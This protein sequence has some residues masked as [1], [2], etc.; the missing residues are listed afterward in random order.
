MDQLGGRARRQLARRSC[1]DLRSDLPEPV[2]ERDG[3]LGFPRTVF[4][5]GSASRVHDRRGNGCRG[6][7]GPV[8]IRSSC[9]R[10]APRPEPRPARSWTRASGIASDGWLYGADGSRGSLAEREVRLVLHHPHEPIVARDWGDL[11][12]VDPANRRSVNE[13]DL[14]SPFR[15]A[16][17][18]RPLAPRANPACPGVCRRL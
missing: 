7:R 6:L 10:N 2:G 16:W 1:L 5:P 18:P 9:P 8:D 3:T 11:L 14:V 15:I 4:R 17:L 12:G 13:A